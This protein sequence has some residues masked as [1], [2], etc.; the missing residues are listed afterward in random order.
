M[1]V[2]EQMVINNPD[3]EVGQILD[4]EGP[5]CPLPAPTTP[6]PGYS[7]NSTRYC[8]KGEWKWING[9]VA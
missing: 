2:T 4:L 6:P 9:E 7:P 1:K 5:D 8:D 3:L